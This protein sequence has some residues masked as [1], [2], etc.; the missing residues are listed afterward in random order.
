MKLIKTSLLNA[1]AVAMKM[2]TMLGINKVLAVYVGPSGYAM[3]GQLQNALAM[4]IAFTAGGINTGVIKYTAEFDGDEEEQN[5]IWSTSFWISVTLSIVISCL[6][7]GFSEALSIYFLKD[8]Q[9]QFVFQVFAFTLIFFVMNGQIL[10]VL[11]GK[12]EILSYVGA[13]IVGSLVGFVITISLTWFYELKGALT[14]LALNQS[15]VFFFSIIFIIRLSWFKIFKPLKGF[16]KAS[17]IKLLKFSFMGLVGAIVVPLSHIFIRLHLSNL[18]GWEEAGYWDAIWRISAIYLMFV[19][20]VLSVYFLPKF[21]EINER[22]LLRME[23]LNGYKVILPVVIF[24]SL[25]IYLMRDVL[26]VLL[27]SD[28]FVAM[29]ELFF[30]QLMGDI[31][32]ISSWLLG[33]IVL[34]KAMITIVV[35]S[36]ILFALSFYFL[37]VFFTENYGLIGVTYAHSLNYLFHFLFMLTVVIRKRVI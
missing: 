27:F 6:V 28:E 7:F 25:S 13:N 32:K 24:L 5:K 36:E 18:L 4:I 35:V 10:A 12:K 9:Y 3:I 33:F 19:T 37:S 26:I 16:D 11:N 22:K 34:A 2:L 21:S 15:I 20:T 1:I 30:W 23:L 8:I 29:R 14:A 31:L 17:S